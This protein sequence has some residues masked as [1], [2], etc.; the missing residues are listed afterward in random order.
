[1]QVAAVL[2]ERRCR[3]NRL[4]ISGFGNGEEIS[5]CVTLLFGSR[6]GLEFYS[7]PRIG[8]RAEKK[9]PRDLAVNVDVVKALI[10]IRSLRL[11]PIASCPPVAPE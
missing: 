7:S 8:A 6:A 3:C 2:P 1:M 11:L 4:S 9:D 10:E 5:T